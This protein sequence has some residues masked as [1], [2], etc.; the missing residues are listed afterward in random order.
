MKRDCLDVKGH[1][2]DDEDA[3]FNI[4]KS[5]SLGWTI[6][7]GATAHMTPHWYDLNEY[8]DMVANIEVTI[9][10]GKK[11]RVSGIRSVG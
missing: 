6:N 2:N 4:E 1:G 3:A 9:A 11:I 10:G 5:Q 8:K 7:S